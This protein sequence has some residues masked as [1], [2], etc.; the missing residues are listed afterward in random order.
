MLAGPKIVITDSNLTS[1]ADE[2]VLR[3]AGITTLRLQATSGSEVI[4]GLSEAA[5]DALIVQ[6]APVPA[7]VLD[8]APG[9]RFI[10]RLGIGYDMTDVAAATERGVA[11]ASTPGYCADEVVAHTLAMALWLLRGL[12]RYAAAVRRG[13][14]S[15][16]EALSARG[17]AVG[18]HHRRGRDRPHRRAGCLA[19]RGARLRRAGLRSVRRP[20]VA[21]RSVP[22]R[23][24]PL[25]RPATR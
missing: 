16:A 5:A 24:P 6:R 17:P 1:A 8:A 10:S 4:A 23:R 25:P 2:Q 15:A 19:G 3:D 9:V 13:T 12:G 18:H 20:A 22:A 14:W 11:V 7:T 21:S